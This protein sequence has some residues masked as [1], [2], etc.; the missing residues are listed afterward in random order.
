MPLQL[1]GYYCFRLIRSTIDGLGGFI[2][3]KKKKK[4]KNETNERV[5]VLNEKKQQVPDQ[6]KNHWY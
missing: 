2:I 6:P 5:C 3:P 4:K 1:N